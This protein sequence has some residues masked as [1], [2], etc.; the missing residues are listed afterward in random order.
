MSSVGGVKRLLFLGAPGAGKGTYASKLCKTW[1]IPHISTGDIIREEIRSGSTLGNEF[2][3]YS[4]KGALVPDQ[5]VV[6]IARKRLSLPDAKVGYILDGFPRNVSQAEALK[7]ISNPTLCVNIGLP[8]RF[9]IMK[10]AGRRVCSDCG[11][12]YN[13]A[14]IREGMYDMPP[15]LPKPEDC[16]KC[17][18]QP[19]LYQ[20]DDDAEGV[21]AER[22][23]TYQAET[24]P[25]IEFY[26]NM[27]IL[28]NFEVTKGIKD[29]PDITAK[30][31]SCC[32]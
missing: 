7:D 19:K 4:N 6:D 21:V 26:S 10:L 27:G 9:L 2:M 24:A 15:L 28:V 8:D 29:L 14:D 1:N 3:S 22:L 30:I 12:N 16:D 20:R 32:V 17:K 18:G 13:V 11:K 31:L 5:L 23:R 25:L